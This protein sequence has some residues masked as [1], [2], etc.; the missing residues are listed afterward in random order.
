MTRLW[1]GASVAL[2]TVLPQ[3]LDAQQRRA[4]PSR[5]RER[6]TDVWT[7]TFN[8]QRIGVALEADGD[9]ETDRIGAKVASVT[10]G[11]PADDAGIRT[12]D[13][14]TRFGGTR[15][16]GGEPT[17]K[18]VELA[19][20]LEPG[21][22]VRVEYQRS[23]SRRN[24]TIVAEDLG[25]SNFAV[26][27]PR[28]RIE[29]MMPAIEGMRDNFTM[30]MG[31]PGIRLA[32]LNEGLGEYFG[33][34]EGLLVLEAP[35]DSTLPLR[36]GDVITSIDGRTPNSV[37]HAMR[38]LGSYSEGE[39]VKFQ[40]M[41]KQQRQTIDWKVSERRV[42]GTGVYRFNAPHREP[43]VRPN[44]RVAPGRVLRERA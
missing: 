10:P 20:K 31:W 1:L 25:G 44:V 11:G 43:M 8:R 32:E 2:L 27:I 28:M 14:I 38:I 15:L 40:V 22:T 17:K 4:E 36:A 6:E 26:T 23:G 24:A 5:P 39:S 7:S 3:A 34:S 13:I 19:Q 41:R 29:Q 18:L 9:E 35:S 37:G 30:F 42:G 21:D 16:G 33:T 12:G